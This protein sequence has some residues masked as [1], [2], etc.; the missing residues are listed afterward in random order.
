MALKGGPVGQD[1]E[2]GGA[3]R[4][5][6]ARKRRR[7]EV[8]ADQALGRARLLDLGNER[9]SRRARAA[10]DGTREAANGAARFA[11]N[12]ISVASGIALGGVDLARAYR[13]R[14]CARIS[15]IDSSVRDG[16]EAVQRGLGTAMIERGGGQLARLRRG[17][18]ARPATISAAAALRTRDVAIGACAR[19]RARRRKRAWHCTL[20]RRPSARPADAASSPTSAGSMVEARDLAAWSSST[21]LVG[22]VVVI[23]SRP[24]EP[25]T[26]QT[27]VEPRLPSTSTSGS[28][29]CARKHAEELPLHAGRVGERAEQ[30]EDGARAELD[31]RRPDMLHRGVMSRREHEADARPPRC[32]ARSRPAQGRS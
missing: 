23:S 1:R 6:G 19:R 18:S 13:L 28:S 27:R 2:A 30:I 4:L 12:V 32:S 21:A 25:C 15:A 16:D 26:D 10:L 29:H 17:P 3:A 14:S 5:I 24:S 9:R 31:P 7:I 22:P 20:H 11:A 8:G